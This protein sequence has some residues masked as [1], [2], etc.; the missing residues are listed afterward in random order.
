M[1]GV[2]HLFIP[3]VKNIITGHAGSKT[4]PFSRLDPSQNDLPVDT[5]KK[6]PLSQLFSP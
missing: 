6:N 3:D 5:V 1:D 2:M 4:Q